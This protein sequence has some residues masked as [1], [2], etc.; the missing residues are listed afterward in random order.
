MAVE[1]IYTEKE[2]CEN[3]Y[4]NL[5]DGK[6]TVTLEVV[7]EKGESLWCGNILIIN[8]KTGRIVSCNS[9]NNEL[10]FTLDSC[11]RVIVN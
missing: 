3:V 4:F 6:N 2:K 7:D 8:K 5:K 9:I 1:G 10:G 11:G